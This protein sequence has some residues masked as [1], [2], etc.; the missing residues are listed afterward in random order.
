MGLFD[1]LEKLITE[2][3]SAAILKERLALVADKYSA[4]EQKVA[5]LESENRN[6]KVEN[7]QLKEKKRNLEEQ[8]AQRH[9]Q[10][11]EEVREQ[12]LQ[13]LAAQSEWVT[14]SQVARVLKIGEQLAT[15]HLTDMEKLKLISVSY[16]IESPPEWSL[17]QESRAYLVRHGLLT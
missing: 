17:A 5:D 4:L 10:R 7:D 16:A 14:A 13:V 9:G 12:L 11:L 15:F 6:L 2:H 8:L 1:G 3:G